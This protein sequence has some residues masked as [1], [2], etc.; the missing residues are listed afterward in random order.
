MTK[1]LTITL[2]LAATLTIPGTVHADEPATCSD[3]YVTVESVGGPL[4]VNPIYLTGWEDDPATCTNGFYQGSC[5]AVE[6]AELEP[7]VFTAEA[8]EY[9]PIP[10]VTATVVVLKVDRFRAALQQ[11]TL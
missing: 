1:L 9:Q 5:V 2:A 3:G 4:C 8:Y 11:L 7:V 6:Y 10:V